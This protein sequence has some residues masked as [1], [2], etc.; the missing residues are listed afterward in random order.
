[1]SDIETV[2]Q[3]HEDALL[4][5]PNVQGVGIGRKNEKPVIKV[6]VGMK[7]PVASLQPD[8]VIPSALDGYPT[9]VEEVGEFKAGTT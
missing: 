2:L 7:V 5:L 3:R 8:E 9:D 6:F 1:M 4:D